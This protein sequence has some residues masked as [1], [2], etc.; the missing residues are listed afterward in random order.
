[1]TQG[2]PGINVGHDGTAQDI[3]APIRFQN[4]SGF[5]SLY[6]DDS[7][8]RTARTVTVDTFTD[9]NGLGWS[10][11][12][13]LTPG[14]ITY[15]SNVTPTV[16][17]LTGYGGGEVDLLSAN[18]VNFN[19]V[20]YGDTVIRLGNQGTVDDWRSNLSVSSFGSKAD[21]YIDDSL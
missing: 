15:S 10:R 8:D 16:A 7:A 9:A 19:L 5:N 2:F 18:G 1:S 11:I 6:V 13:G 3:V 21:I 20:N 12:D 17:L 4:W 14:Q